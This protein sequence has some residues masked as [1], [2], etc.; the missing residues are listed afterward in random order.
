MSS[1]AIPPITGRAGTARGGIDTTAI[2]PR[3]QLESLEDLAEGERLHGYAHGS[4]GGLGGQRS[5]SRLR[6]EIE[7]RGDFV[8]VVLSERNGMPGIYAALRLP[9][10]FKQPAR[11]TDRGASFSLTLGEALMHEEGHPPT[12]ARTLNVSTGHGHWTSFWSFRL[13]R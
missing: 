12:R 4:E 5:P 6:V 7:R 13:T 1:P 10:D 9:C 3:G 2:A 11:I 8:Q